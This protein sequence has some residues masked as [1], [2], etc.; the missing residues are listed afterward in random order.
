MRP[1]QQLQLHQFQVRPSC[2][3]S[4][5]SQCTES[6][7][8]ARSPHAPHTNFAHAILTAA[9]ATGLFTPE[10]YAARQR[11]IQDKAEAATVAA[12]EQKE[13]ARREQLLELQV[14]FRSF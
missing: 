12:E 14:A 6:A 3:S 11:E 1:A 9:A 10:E 2:M 5:C 7:A 13:A 4:H 8:H